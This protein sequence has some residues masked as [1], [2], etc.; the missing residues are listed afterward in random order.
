MVDPTIP[1][2]DVP[3]DLPSEM[4]IEAF[5]ATYTLVAA[6]VMQTAISAQLEQDAKIVADCTILPTSEASLLCGENAEM[7]LRATCEWAG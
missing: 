5:S 2:Q 7:Q 4:V 6:V 3:G 1:L